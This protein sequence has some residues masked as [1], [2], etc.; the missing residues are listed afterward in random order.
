M[1]QTK[2]RLQSFTGGKMEAGETAIRS[3]NS[4]VNGRFTATQQGQRPFVAL[5]EWAGV[6]SSLQVILKQD[7]RG[8]YTDKTSG[9]K[10]AVSCGHF[11]DMLS[12]GYHR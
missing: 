3:T 10:T 7:L 12:L 5:T 4:R 1:S 2:S 6:G 9:W 11:P 8:T